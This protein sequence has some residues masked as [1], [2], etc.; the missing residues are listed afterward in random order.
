MRS[1]RRITPQL[2]DRATRGPARRRR[3]M[4][5]RA[6]GA[7]LM[8]VLVGAGMFEQ[9]GLRS[10]EIRRVALPDRPSISPGE[11]VG[12]LWTTTA[13][14]LAVVLFHSTLVS[15]IGTYF[16][17]E[18]SVGFVGAMVMLVSAMATTIRPMLVT[19]GQYFVSDWIG[20]LLP[21]SLAIS[22]G[23]SELDGSS[24][25]D[26][27]IA[28]LV[29][30]PKSTEPAARPLLV[31]SEMVA[32]CSTAQARGASPSSAQTRER[33]RPC[34]F[35]SSLIFALASCAGALA[36]AIKSR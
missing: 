11:A 28:P 3:I 4:K 6:C 26:L 35:S 27:E 31:I 36:R 16:R 33:L 18:G 23:Y 1:I 15:L 8:T 24:Y 34:C 17:R 29:F 7:L 30:G 9:A 21:T 5:W 20:A 25:T 13:I 22:W 14:L 10:D 12:F 2:S 19:F 32:K